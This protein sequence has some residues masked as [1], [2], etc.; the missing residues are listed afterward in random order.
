MTTNLHSNA[1][2]P[3]ADNRGAVDLRATV[4]AIQQDSRKGLLWN[5]VLLVAAA[6]ILFFNSGGYAAYSVALGGILGSANLLAISWLTSRILTQG[7]EGMGSTMALVGAKF[8]ALIGVVGA[9][10]LLLKPALLPFLIGF[11]TS[12]PIIIGICVLRFGR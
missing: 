12:L 3:D 6:T 4:A 2:E 9:I 10:V 11:S 5:V 7:N 1:L 8:V